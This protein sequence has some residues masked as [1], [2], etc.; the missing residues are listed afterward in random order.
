LML[1]F[2]K[3][4]VPLPSRIGFY[5]AMDEGVDKRGPTAWAEKD[6]GMRDSEGRRKMILQGSPHL[7]EK[8]RA[9]Q[10]SQLKKIISYLR[11]PASPDKEK[12]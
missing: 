8:E 11:A 5:E 1:K 9:K 3:E 4:G 12:E 6:W 10:P 7:S 2:R